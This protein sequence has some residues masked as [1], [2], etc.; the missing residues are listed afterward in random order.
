MSNEL[1]LEG[2]QALPI[3]SEMQRAQRT[4]TVLA[5]VVHVPVSLPRHLYTRCADWEHD[6]CV[7][8]SAYIMRG[9]AE[10]TLD[11]L[12]SSGHTETIR[13]AREMYMRCSSWLIDNWTP[14]TTKVVTISLPIPKEL[15]CGGW[16]HWL[17]LEIGRYAGAYIER[18]VI[19]PLT[20]DLGLNPEKVIKELLAE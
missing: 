7:V 2:T 20:L 14:P 17:S 4:N 15:L 11:I 12:P 1:T 13:I 10:F 3:V 5:N 19:T 18:H 16:G 8:A 9:I 6:D